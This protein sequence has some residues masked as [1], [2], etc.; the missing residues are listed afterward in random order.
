MPDTRTAPTSAPALQSPLHTMALRIHGRLSIDA[1]HWQARLQALVRRAP[2][3]RILVAPHPNFEPR[4]RKSLRGH[5][6]ALTVSPLDQA[7]LG[8]HDLVVPL[9][10]SDALWLAER[11]E[12]LPRQRLPV[13]RTDVVRLCDD[14]LALNQRLI[15]LGFGD[16]I[17]ALLPEPQ[18]PCV[19]KGRWSTDSAATHLLRDADDARR[20]A[21][22][23]QDGAY[24]CQEAVLDPR[25]YAS[26]LVVQDGRIRQ[27]MTNEYHCR[28]ALFINGGRVSYTRRLVRSP[29]LPLLE[30]MLAAIG[31]EGL[32]CVDYK[33]RDGRLQLLEI[34]PRLGGSLA[35]SFGA[36][37]STLAG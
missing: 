6:M 13:C 11:R 8:A 3:L 32:C 21:A 7:D 35:Y 34:N 29:H 37:M 19:L 30:R 1:F 36:F 27:H 16:H 24:F 22:A 20:H 2:P 17:P 12:T 14:K 9:R 26:H 4:I 33:V 23:L 10:T 31:F 25:E 28:D 15:A 5:A 18:W